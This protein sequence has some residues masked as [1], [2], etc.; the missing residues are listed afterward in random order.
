MWSARL[1]PRVL[2]LICCV[3]SFRKA[4]MHAGVGRRRHVVCGS[5]TQGRL[6]MTGRP[7]DAIAMPVCHACTEMEAL[8]VVWLGSPEWYGRWQP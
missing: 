6:L 1:A 2:A 3:V 4:C 7:I 5:G 8:I